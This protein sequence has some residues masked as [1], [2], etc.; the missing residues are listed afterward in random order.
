MRDLA[1]LLDVYGELGA[2]DLEALIVLGALALAG[3][4][5]HV[6]FVVTRPK[7]DQ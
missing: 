4:A 6:V 2:S 3:Y 1:F 5:I 7:G